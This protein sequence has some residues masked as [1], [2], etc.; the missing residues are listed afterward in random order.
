MLFSA[1]GWP[2]SRTALADE[3]ALQNPVDAVWLSADLHTSPLVKKLPGGLLT[4]EL[5]RQAVLIAARD[6]LGWDTG[7]EGLGDV[8]P[9]NVDPH[10]PAIRIQ[11]TSPGEKRLK[12]EL[13]TLDKSPVERL[14]THEYEFDPDP[15]RCYALLTALLE[16]ES[17]TTLSD[18]LKKLS[19][20]AAS[21]APANRKPDFTR[22]DELLAK[23]DFVSQFVA[24]RLT[25]Q[26]IRQCGESPELLGRLVRGY[27]HL[28][29]LT[30]SLWSA[31]SDI[32]AARSLLY[33]E[34]LVAAQNDSPTALAY[35]SYA[36]AL[37]GLHA[38]ALDDIAVLHKQSNEPQSTGGVLPAW[39]PLIE[40]Y[41]QFDREKLKAAAPANS[42]VASLGALLTAKLN[43]AS[44]TKRE[45]AERIPEYFEALPEAYGL[46]LPLIPQATGPREQALATTLRNFARLLPNR[47]QQTTEIPPDVRQ[48]ATAKVESAAADEGPGGAEFQPVAGSEFSAAPVQIAG[49]L[50]QVA[51]GEPSWRALAAIIRD[52]AFSTS[53]NYFTYFGGSY[54]SQPM[55]E[56]AQAMTDGHRYDVLIRGYGVD[57]A[58][59]SDDYKR[60]MQGLRIVDPNP[61]MWRL[62]VRMWYVNARGDFLGSRA[63]YD[64]LEQRDFTCDYLMACVG[65]VE[66]MASTNRTVAGMYDDIFS[67][68]QIVSPNCPVAV[69]AAILQNSAPSPEQLAQ[70]EKA[71]GGDA[72]TSRVLG[73]RYRQLRR[74]D[75]AI[76]LLEESVALSP[77]QSAFIA[78][79]DVYRSNGHDELWRPTLERFLALDNPALDDARVRDRIAQDYIAHGNWKQ[80]EPYSLAAAESGA[81][82]A[83]MT[84]SS[85][86]EG[87]EDWEKSEDFIRR[88]SQ[89]Y[90]G[91]DRMQWYVWCRRTGRGDLNEARSLAEQFRAAPRDRD[92]FAPEAFGVYE[93]LEGQPQKALEQFNT[94]WARSPASDWVGMHAVLLTAEQE[95]Q[96]AVDAALTKLLSRTNADD[97]KTAAYI[98]DAV[99]LLVDQ[100]ASGERPEL[101]ATPLMALID[102]MSIDA[103]CKYGYFLGRLCELRG[104]PPLAEQCYRRAI[105]TRQFAQYNVTLATL[106][107]AGLHQE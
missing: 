81:A 78:L 30:Q 9:D 6:E 49:A 88:L 4:R 42:D 58:G 85:V 71:A 84:A 26:Q 18:T 64:A 95:N 57:R 55:L 75:D 86:Y 37:C 44:S 3:V 107:L 101:E 89:S 16:R 70:W 61:W 13:I 15:R 92:F 63:M 50:A 60:F 23:M 79:A 74:F 90:Q 56:A 12:L 98:R 73:Q 14:L 69:R 77:N 36:R 5:V 82:W 68:I 22:I 97:P 51:G 52:E 80:A 35:R 7:D 38:L 100:L 62:F 103:R 33:A 1:L 24:V 54:S 41:V 46:F 94:A 10:R 96:R 17:R 20:D 47:L 83:L 28:A 25:H 45:L 8:Q 65:E 91:I 11:V 76:R 53:T 106:R 34:R 102:G 39:L 105:D 66:Q 104:N 32:C 43:D 93:I 19:A 72:D 99:H 67:Q 48:L 40:A 29:A 27:S 21:P 87:L 59:R 31:T 2:L